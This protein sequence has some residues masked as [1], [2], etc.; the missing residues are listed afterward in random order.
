MPSK[1]L[2]SPAS[3]FPTLPII[4]ARRTTSRFGKS[5][6]GSRTPGQNL[7][8]RYENRLFTAL[9]NLNVGIVEHNPWF[10]YEDSAHQ[11]GI[12]CPDFLIR[13]SDLGPIIIECKYT[14]MSQAF[15]KLTG[16]YVPVVDAVLG[17]EGAEFRDAAFPRNVVPSHLMICRTLVLGC[18]APGATIQTALTLPQPLYHWTGL[19]P[20]FWK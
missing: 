14:Y 10:E 5:R 1:F 11:H 8:L 16:L 7:G 17:A 2:A 20:V 4:R 9:R 13:A 18:P 6:P 15:T 3:P 12:C 19:G